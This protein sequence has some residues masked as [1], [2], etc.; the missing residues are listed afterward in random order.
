MSAWI[1][2]TI[3]GHQS[4]T[5]AASRHGFVR[6]DI[7][8]CQLFYCWSARWNSTRRFEKTV[9]T[10]EHSLLWQALLEEAVEP[11]YV[12]LIKKLYTSRTAMVCSGC[13]S[14][15]F[16]LQRGVE[17]GDPMAGLSFLLDMEALFWSLKRLSNYDNRVRCRPGVTRQFALSAEKGSAELD[18]I[19]T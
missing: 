8:C 12:Q 7:I 11:S 9:D 19:V 16:S 4:D 5:Q 13:E 14:R 15:Q 6:P 2:H 10:V 17:E 18:R 3:V 1:Q